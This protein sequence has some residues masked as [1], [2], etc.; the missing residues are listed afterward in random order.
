MA[1]GGTQADRRRDRTSS[2]R[3]S[4]VCAPWV[5][6]AG[7][8]RPGGLEEEPLV[9][10]ATPPAGT[11]CQRPDERTVDEQIGEAKRLANGR[12]VPTSEGLQGVAGVDDRME[13]APLER[14]QQCREPLW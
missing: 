1:P 8:E 2:E 14:A 10:R 13:A 5:H 4:W 3:S 11:G 6:V 7:G 12:L 9:A